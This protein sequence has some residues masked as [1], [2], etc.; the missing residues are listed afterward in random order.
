MVTYIWVNIG[1]GNGLLPLSHYLNQC[2]IIIKGVLW[3]SPESN[4][5]KCAL[6]LDLCN[7]FEYHP[8]RIITTS[9]RGQWVNSHATVWHIKHHM[10]L[11][12]LALVWLC[13]Q[14]WNLWICVIQLSALFRIA[15]LSLGHDN[16][17]F[18]SYRKTSYI[19]STLVGNKIVDNSDVV[20]AS[21]VGA[22]PTTSSFST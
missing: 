4:F 20:G 21:P 15:S 1:S 11:L 2:W 19:N 9:P 8:F 17:W 18:L 22:A 14:F 13:H 7:V 10:V 12:C 16:V 5:T 3:H 6:V